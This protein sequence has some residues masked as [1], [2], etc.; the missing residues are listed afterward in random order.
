[1]T[2]PPALQ[3]ILKKLRLGG[4][5]GHADPARD[6]ALLLSLALVVIIASVAWNVWFFFEVLNAQPV[7][8]APATEEETDTVAPLR[9]LFEER[10][11]EEARYRNEYRFVDPG[12]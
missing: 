11:A 7:V 6:W 4:H 3:K 5:S 2:L 1:M 12:N 8:E 10:A 9:T